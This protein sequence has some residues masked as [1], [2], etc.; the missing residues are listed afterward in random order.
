MTRKEL[1]YLETQLG[2]AKR[3][4]N[5]KHCAAMQAVWARPEYRRLRRARLRAAM[6]RPQWR[7]RQRAGI[8][9]AWARRR[10]IA[11]LTGLPLRRRKK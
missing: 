8:A 1:E 4:K 3:R 5:K 10:A 9:R 7:R 2:A 11:K 6:A